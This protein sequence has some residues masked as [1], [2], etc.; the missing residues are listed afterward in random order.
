MFPT[1]FAPHLKSLGIAFLSIFFLFI[2]CKKDSGQYFQVTIL[3]SEGGVVSIDSGS[4][5]EGTELSLLA[6]PGDNYIFS[7]WSDGSNSN[8]LTITIN[9]N[10][11][12]TANFEYYCE[13]ASDLL[14]LNQSSNDLFDIIYPITPSGSYNGEMINI[15]GNFWQYGCVGTYIDYN[16]DGIR[17]IVGF[18][19][20]YDNFVDMPEGYTGYE[21]KQPI[22]FFLG[23]CQGNFTPDPINDNLYLGLVHGREF[24]FGDFNNDNYADFFLV[25]HGYDKQPFPGEFLKSLISDGNGGYIE[26]D[27]TDLVAFYHSGATGDYDNDGDLD[28]IVIS[29]GGPTDLS[30]IYENNGGVLTAN[31]ELVDQSLFSSMLHVELHDINND[32]YLDLILGGANERIDI[33]ENLSQIIYGDGGS[34]VGN[35]SVSLPE[36]EISGFGIVTDLNFYDLDDDGTDEIIITRTRDRSEADPNNFYQG[37]LV[38]V[39]QQNGSSFI[40]RTNDFIEDYYSET[41]NWIVWAD[42]RDHDNDGKVEFY[43]TANPNTPDYLEWELSQGFLYRID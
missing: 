25:G 16:N 38:Q 17:D 7:G 5:I 42:F 2:A 35:E 33:G 23:D 40:D 30:A 8:P 37:W 1:Q 6:T 13:Y 43:N 28:V 4:Y 34:F 3:S 22:R 21:R 19:N 12:I 9:S 36:S 18:E 10:I 41:G 14:D 32:G 15:I 29:P 31:Q 11:E 27:Y 20:N 24:L 26:N 39:I